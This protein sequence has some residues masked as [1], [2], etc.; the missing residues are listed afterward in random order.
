MLEFLHR[1]E[2]HAVKKREIDDNSF[3]RTRHLE[4][5]PYYEDVQLRKKYEALYL[6]SVGKLGLKIK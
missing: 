1:A 4:P 6:I 3:S 5:E 2:N